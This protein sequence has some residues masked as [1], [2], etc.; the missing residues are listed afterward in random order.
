MSEPRAPDPTLAGLRRSVM[1]SNS[2]ND[3]PPRYLAHDGSGPCAVAGHLMPSGEA[4]YIAVPCRGCF[5][6]AP[7]PGQK[8]CNCGITGCTLPHPNLSWQVPS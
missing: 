3:G 2:Y 7:N 6:D 4:A 8:K 5:P 1:V